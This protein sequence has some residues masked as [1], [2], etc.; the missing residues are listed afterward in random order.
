MKLSE[1]E[2][3]WLDR[4]EKRE[5]L[6]LPVT[7]WICVLGGILS[8]AEGFFLIHKLQVNHITDSESGVLFALF[9]FAMAG[10]WFGFAFSKWRGDIKSRLFLRLIREH[11]NKDT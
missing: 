9:F 7:R 4:W 5:R 10:V 3:R 1:Q 2:L 6:W 11:E 8:L